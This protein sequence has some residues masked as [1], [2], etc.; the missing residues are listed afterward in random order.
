M[1]TENLCTDQLAEA[2]CSGISAYRLAKENECSVWSVITRLRKAG[3]RQYPSG[4]DL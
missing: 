2:Y 4:Q 3:V 1:G